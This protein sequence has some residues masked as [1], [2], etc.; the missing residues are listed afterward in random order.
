MNPNLGGFTSQVVNCF[1]ETRLLYT[2]M[3]RKLYT[4]LGIDEFSDYNSSF[5]PDDVIEPMAIDLQTIPK[6]FWK[7]TMN[8][9]ETYCPD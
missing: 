7:L 4:D 5:T 2:K 1:V 3:L 8:W 9:V 6:K